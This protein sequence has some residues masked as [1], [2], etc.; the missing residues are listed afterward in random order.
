MLENPGL[1][2]SI[3][4]FLLLLGPLVFVHEMG[5]Y[6]VGRWCGVKAE[7]FSIGFGKE[8]FGWYDRLGTRWRVSVLPLGGYVQFAGD[9]N[10][11]S[12][13]DAEWQ[14]LPDAER[15]KTFQSKSL[16]QR[17]A[18]VF[19]G[20]AINFLFAIL[21][22][23]GFAMVYGKVVTPPVV[24]NVEPGTA[25]AEYGLQ[26][27]DH[28]LAINGEKIEYFGDIRQQVAPWPGGEASL[29]IERDGAELT[30]TITLGTAYIEDRFGN[31]SP[32]G[33][34]GIAPPERVIEPASLLEAPQIGV[35]QTVRVVRFM[36]TTL[37]QIIT[38]SRSLKELGGPLKIGQV[39]GERLAAGTA[40]FVE[41]VALISI[42]L[43]FINLLPIPMLDGGHLLFYAIEAVRRRPAG[44]RMQE[45]AFRFGLSFVLLFMVLVT[46]NDVLSFGLLRVE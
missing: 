11:A 33:L 36:I 14:N 39:S 15:N 41:L 21:I 10:P 37:G 43:G 28:I 46:V 35:E 24:E 38:G 5:H 3:G 23:A 6:L 17:A 13:P 25:A 16:W 42:N 2:F 31:R 45:W 7:V 9:M 30:K 22:F 8:I 18:I 12:Q 32:Y 27:G 34:L 29:L 19:A 26:E 1:L 4:A 20:P 40:E 44:P